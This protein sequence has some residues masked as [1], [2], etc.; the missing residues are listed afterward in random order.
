MTVRRAIDHEVPL[1]SQN[2]Y[3]GVPDPPLAA[4]VNSTDAPGACGLAG[5][6]GGF[7]TTVAHRSELST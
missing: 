1:Y 3:S 4:A 6:G 5:D 2:W 7:R